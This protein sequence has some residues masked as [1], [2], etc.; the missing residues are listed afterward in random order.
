MWIVPSASVGSMAKIRTNAA[1]DGN[2]NDLD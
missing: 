2:R 1:R